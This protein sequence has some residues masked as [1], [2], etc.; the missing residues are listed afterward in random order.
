MHAH[1]P[2]KCHRLTVLLIAVSDPN[3]FSDLSVVN[4][5]IR[6]AL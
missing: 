6:I 4:R 3:S 1:R 2:L 5:Q